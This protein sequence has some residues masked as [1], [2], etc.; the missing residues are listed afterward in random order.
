MLSLTYL[1]TNIIIFSLPLSKGHSKEEL[2]GCNW[3]LVSVNIPTVALFQDR[4]GP[5]KLSI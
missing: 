5:T 4:P 3:R 2:S 1:V